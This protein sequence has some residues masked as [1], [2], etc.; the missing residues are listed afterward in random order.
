MNTY[1]KFW[2]KKQT[3]PN[4]NGMSVIYYKFTRHFYKTKKEAVTSLN[5][6]LSEKLDYYTIFKVDK[7][8]IKFT[9]LP[10]D[11][12][13]NIHYSYLTGLNIIHAV[14]TTPICILGKGR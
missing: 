11:H 10:S 5:S 9:L 13:G 7:N 6:L 2:K 14:R 8:G 4:K 1:K 12:A 3:K